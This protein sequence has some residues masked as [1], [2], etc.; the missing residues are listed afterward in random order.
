MKEKNRALWEEMSMLWILGS[1]PHAAPY[2]VPL[3][4][5][6]HLTVPQLPYTSNGHDN[7]TH[8]IG[9]NKKM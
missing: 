5:W 2:C 4:R 1:N 6:F 3:G 8:S 9:L 7:S